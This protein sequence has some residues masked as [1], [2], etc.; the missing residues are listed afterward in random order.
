MNTSLTITVHSFVDLITNSSSE[1]FVAADQNTVKAIKKLVENLVAATGG[2]ANADD[3]FSF[4]LVYT[5]VDQNYDEVEMTK[6]EIAAK[7]KEVGKILKET[8]AEGVSYTEKQVEDAQTWEFGDDRDGPSQCKVRV[9]AKAPTNKHAKD[10]AK[11]LS[12]LTSIF[13]IEESYN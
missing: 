6:S 5:C 3:L 10:A 7:R 4:D 12:D 8:P 2:T 13:T 1:I 9:T 11:V